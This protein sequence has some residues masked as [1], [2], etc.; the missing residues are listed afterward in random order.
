MSSRIAKKKNKDKII[1]KCISCC[2]I[3]SQNKRTLPCICPV[4]NMPCKAIK[5]KW[6][7]EEN[8]LD[9]IVDL[10]KHE[11]NRNNGENDEPRVPMDSEYVDVIFIDQM[12]QSY[13][14]FQNGSIS[15][16]VM[17]SY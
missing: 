5:E 4:S 9:F 15:I 12:E 17:E 8:L 2:H 11:C 7:K 14:E 1:A 6:V 10:D 3:N 13:K 16:E